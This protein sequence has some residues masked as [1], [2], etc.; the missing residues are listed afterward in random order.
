M[1]KFK[2]RKD[3]KDIEIKSPEIPEINVETNIPEVE[4]D[5]NS[6][7]YKE[8]MKGFFKGNVHKF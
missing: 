2:I 7:E 4:I 1:P 5:A 6:P 8:G 3:D